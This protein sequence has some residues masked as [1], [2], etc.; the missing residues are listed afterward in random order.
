MPKEM[1]ETGTCVPHGHEIALARFDEKDGNGQLL[2]AACDG[3]YK[4]TLFIMSDH[5]HGR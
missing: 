3:R 2:Q 4:R 1:I 5:S